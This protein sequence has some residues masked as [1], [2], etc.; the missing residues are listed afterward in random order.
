MASL[1]EKTY[2]EISDMTDFIGMIP[3]ETPESNLFLAEVSAADTPRIP[4]TSAT[5]AAEV[6]TGGS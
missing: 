5:Q 6:P 2:K 1:Q 4:V 3:Y